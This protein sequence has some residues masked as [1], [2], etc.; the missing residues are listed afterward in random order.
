MCAAVHGN[1]SQS[2]EASLP[3]H[4]VPCY[5]TQVKAPRLAVQPVSDQK[6]CKIGPRVL[7]MIIGNLSPILHRF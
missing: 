7:L 4:S 5:P 6:R 1:P 2:H 3:S